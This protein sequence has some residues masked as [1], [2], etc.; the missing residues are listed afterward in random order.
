MAPRR[1]LDGFAI[2]YHSGPH[3]NRMAQAFRRFAGAV[4]LDKIQGY[5]EQHQHC[6]DNKVGYFA[7]KG[8]NSTGYEEE[9]NQGILEA[10]QE[11]QKQMAFLVITEQVG[12]K[13]G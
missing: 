4:L 2:T 13:F 8:G 1:H 5:T 3:R 12:T 7:G 10:G 11:L 6:D 9:N